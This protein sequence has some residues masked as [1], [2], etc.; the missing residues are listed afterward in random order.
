MLARA[1]KNVLVVLLVVIAGWVLYAIGIFDPIVDLKPLTQAK[2]KVVGV[3]YQRQHQS[4]YDGMKEEMKKMGYTEKK[5]VV[6]NEMQV[7]PGPTFYKDV[8]NAAKK[9][10]ADNVD[11]L[12]VTS[13]QIDK[14]ALEL[15]KGTNIPV[16]FMTRFHDPLEFGLIASYKSSGNNSTGIATNLAETVQKNLFFFKEID[17]KIKKIGVFTE[18]FMLP[19]GSEAVLAELKK[20]APRFDITIVEYQSKNPPD[21]TSKNWHELA[22]KIKPGEIDGLYHLAS[23]FYDKQ[24]VDETELA[25]RLQIPHSVPSSDI[26]T[27]GSFSFA[28][29]FHESGGQ[30]AVIIDKIF[31]GAKPADIPIEFGSK[32]I[33]IL[34]TKRASEAGFTFPNSM[35]SIA[36]TI[37]AK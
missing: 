20:Q 1:L 8:E 36:E 27:G 19:G 4:A 21:A 26:P 9:H 33:L 32:N 16:V 12:F 24:E 3:I 2:P 18:G 28:D 31:K 29:D 34:Q 15:T 13:E 35:I 5:D 10:I 37:I 22:D 30:A 6:Y 23:H 7:N 11:L 17:S 25:G 14:I